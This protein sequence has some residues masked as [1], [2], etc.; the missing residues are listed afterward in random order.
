MYWLPHIEIGS[1]RVQLPMAD[2]SACDSVERRGLDY[3]PPLLLWQALQAHCGGTCSPNAQ[4]SAPPAA[5]HLAP[6]A[7]VQANVSFA[8]RTRILFLVRRSFFHAEASALS[9]RELSLA[10]PLVDE[11]RRLAIL[12]LS[13]E[14]LRLLGEA[15]EH[16][17]DEKPNN[18][19]QSLTAHFSP[20]AVLAHRESVARIRRSASDDALL[21]LARERADELTA[22]WAETCT[23]D[24][25][26]TASPSPCG[27]VADVH[28][29]DFETKLEVEKLAAL[30]E[31][32]AG[33][34][35]DFNNPLAIMRGRAELLL[36]DER[37]PERRRHLSVIVAQAVRAF[38]M[39][40]DLRLCSR[41]PELEPRDFDF[42][43][44]L[45]EVFEHWNLETASRGIKLTL[46]SDH[47][48]LP[49]RG[50]E[51]QLRAAIDAI[52]KNACE[53]IGREG[54]M[55]LRL[56]VADPAQAE[57]RIEDDGPGIAPEHRRH[58]FDPFFSSRQ[59]GR[60]LGFGLS[61]ARRIVEMHGGTIHVESEP[62]AGATCVVR[63]P[64]RP[65][66]AASPDVA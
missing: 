35:H 14:W 42:A 9:A 50:D 32:A 33:V 5:E 51:M 12:S 47:D 44:F 56:T 21:P 10:N 39:I 31:F 2:V 43:A 7:A 27:Q 1:M 18:V 22:V 54:Q 37:D 29:G 46:I 6:P 58:I 8:L 23:N 49:F 30:A 64:I 4:P 52:C 61:K 24:A 26:S 17:D 15:A 63:L 3:D 66:T 40:A 57:I 20:K 11:S 25:P 60:G 41:P 59:A 19:F 28:E 34:G 45:A 48:A 13:P 16:S 38:E 36:E 62:G 55:V 65:A 53:A